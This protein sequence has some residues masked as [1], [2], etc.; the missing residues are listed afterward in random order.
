[1]MR[2]CMFCGRQAK[3][4]EFD[5]ECFRGPRKPLSP[6]AKKSAMW[7]KNEKDWGEYAV[8]GIAAEKM[9]AFQ[10]LRKNGFPL[11]GA[12]MCPKVHRYV[13]CE[14]S[15]K[16]FAGLM[17]MEA[18]LRWTAP[19]RGLQIEMHQ[20]GSETFR[21]APGS[22]DLV[23]TSPPYWRDSG[24]IENYADEATQSHIRFADYE[25][26]LEG[27]LGQ[28]IRNSYVALKQGGILALNVSDEL[29]GTVTE[30]AVKNGFVYLQTESL[31]LRLSKIIGRK[32]QPGGSWKTEPVLVFRRK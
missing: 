11:I 13:G 4:T 5:C 19:S 2:V 9:T 1:M 16:T 3:Q 23:F 24:S 18:D 29:A 15:T 10:R 12:F 26:W 27:F 8:V 7:R 28:T 21:P 32:Q 14:P 17:Q 30:Q 25:S 20:R 22:V 6:P 31:R